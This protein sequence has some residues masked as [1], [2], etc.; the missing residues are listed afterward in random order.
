MK[1]VTLH[2]ISPLVTVFLYKGSLKGISLS[3][4]SDQ[5][6]SPLGLPRRNRFSFVATNDLGLCPKNPQAF[7]KA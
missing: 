7:E 5:E 4:E 1:I 6:A 3:A 2:I